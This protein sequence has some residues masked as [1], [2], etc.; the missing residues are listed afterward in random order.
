MASVSTD[1][2]GNRTVQFKGIDG[3]RRSIRLGTLPG[4]DVGD[5]REKV[6][7]LET[8]AKNERSPDR[9]TV[10]WLGRIDDSIYDKLAAGGLAEARPSTK[11]VKAKRESLGPFLN[12]YIAK[13][14][15]VKRGTAL[16]YGHTR[17]CLVDY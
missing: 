17:R 13:R 8:Y 14:S 1:K 9:A 12:S 7:L 10:S 15:D 6:A 2:N 4:S 3:K 16:V 11:P 5:I